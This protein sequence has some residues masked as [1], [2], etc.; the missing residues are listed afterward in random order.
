[1]LEKKAWYLNPAFFWGRAGVYFIIWIWLAWFFFTKS[2]QQD[3]SKDPQLTVQMQRRAPV[4]TILF[5]FSLTFAMFDW[6]MSLEP[7]WYS[8]IFG[9]YFFAASTVAIFALLIV[10]CLGLRAAGLLGEAVNVEHFHDLGKMMFGFVVFHAYIGFSQMMLIWYASIPEEL[11][12]YHHRWH[13]GG[14]KGVSMLIVIGHF[15]V[16]F[17]F[18]MSR[19]IKRRLPLLGFGAAWL[20]VMHVVDIY[21]FVMPNFLPGRFVMHWMD[22]A[23]L[24]AVGG[25]YFGFV[26]WLMKRYPLIPIGDPRLGRALRFQNA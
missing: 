22:L 20:L 16:P 25:V 7:T 23:A 13:G 26:F 17:V 1:V 11:T 4:A 5:G 19:H 2:T 14:W 24:M 12:F 6:V 10:T 9:V 3:Q 15:A 21:W 18:L 8:T